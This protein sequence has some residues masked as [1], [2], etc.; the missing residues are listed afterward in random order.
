[1]PR[2]QIARP[3][4]LTRAWITAFSIEFWNN[5]YQE[6]S[7]L[8][9]ISPN[10]GFQFA[11]FGIIQQGKP[12]TNELVQ[13]IGVND[14]LPTPTF[15]LLQSQAGVLVPAFVQI[16]LGSVREARP[17]E[18]RNCV[19]DALQPGRLLAEFFERIAQF[20]AFRILRQL[21]HDRTVH[22]SVGATLTMLTRITESLV[23][24][25]R[26]LGLVVLVGLIAAVTP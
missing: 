3:E 7:V 9:V 2:P 5:T 20:V 22:G 8:S 21:S 23:A 13:V 14:N 4:V 6:P 24:K 10:A 26:T 16:L 17:Q 15:R 25:V 1:L 11:R 18:R 19:D 12:S